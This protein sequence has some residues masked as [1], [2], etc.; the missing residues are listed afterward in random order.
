MPRSL[1][2]APRTAARPTAPTDPLENHVR[3][4]LLSDELGE[5]L[6][7]TVA[8][9]HDILDLTAH[10]ETIEPGVE[11]LPGEGL[12]LLG[13]PSIELAGYLVAILERPISGYECSRVIDENDVELRIHEEVARVA[14]H[15]ID[16]HVEHLHS[17]QLVAPLRRPRSL[18]HDIGVEVAVLDPPLERAKGALDP[19]LHRGRHH[20]EPQELVQLVGCNLGLIAFPVPLVT[21]PLD[22]LERRVKDLIATLEGGLPRLGDSHPDIFD[23]DH[24]GRSEQLFVLLVLFQPDL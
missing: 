5:V 18:L 12:Q 2:S 24:L 4:S 8:A 11:G 13:E 1:R 10:E 22:G 7:Q 3:F 16:E 15:V 6:E 9:F 23:L 21:A 14:V 17:G 20:V 19:S